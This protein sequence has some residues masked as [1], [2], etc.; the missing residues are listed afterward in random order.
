MA[1]HLKT[2]FYARETNYLCKN[3]SEPMYAQEK[4]ANSMQKIPI[5]RYE[6]R[7]IHH[8]ALIRQELEILLE[9]IA[10]WFIVFVIR[11]GIQTLLCFLLL[12]LVKHILKFFYVLNLAK[13]MLYMKM[14]NIYC[15]STLRVIISLTTS[16][17]YI[18]HL[19]R[20]IC[21]WIF[22]ICHTV[23]YSEVA[24]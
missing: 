1:K 13:K 6:P 10:H 15:Y 5:W 19:L 17:I 2:N 16:V 20:K 7:L 21:W 12:K 18:L 9:N 11:R 3:S 23:I 4:H 22:R 14:S 24:V 8:A